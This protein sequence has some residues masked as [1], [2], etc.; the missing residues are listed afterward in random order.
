MSLRLFDLTNAL[1]SAYI[2]SKDN[3][4]LGANAVCLALFVVGLYVLSSLLM[5]GMGAVV[6]VVALLRSISRFCT[7]WMTH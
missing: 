1:K 6:S 2:P 7:F 3:V 5:L 4:R